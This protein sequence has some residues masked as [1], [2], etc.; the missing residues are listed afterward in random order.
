MAFH[1]QGRWL[2][3]SHED[4]KIRL[5][6]VTTGECL[7]I[8]AD[9]F[10]KFRSFCFSP[11]GRLLVYALSSEPTI[12]IR[13]VQSGQC[14]KILR[15]H[16]DNVNAVAYSPKGDIIASGSKDETIKLW[17]AETGE[18]IK[19]LRVSRL[20]EKMNITDVIGLTEAQKATLKSLGAVEEKEMKATVV[21]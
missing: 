20:Y 12:Q 1:P 9:H 7:Q 3:S 11:C 21:R 16:N 5:W 10:G 4:A 13:D 18:C 15:G 8:F 19:T 6:D 17:A 14:L 2:A